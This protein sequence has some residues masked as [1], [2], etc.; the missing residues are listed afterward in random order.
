M[1][2]FFYLIRLLIQIRTGFAEVLA[3]IYVALHFDRSTRLA[4][5]AF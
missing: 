4:V 1:H 2:S 5:T 3:L